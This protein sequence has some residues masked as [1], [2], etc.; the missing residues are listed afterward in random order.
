MAYD[1]SVRSVTMVAGSAVTPYRFLALAATGKVDHVASAGVM[2]D[3][4]A[5]EAAS[6]VDKT[7][8]MGLPD[9]CVVKV[10]CGGTL[11]RGDKVESNAS[12]Q[13]ITF[14]ATVGHVS[15]GVALEAG[16]ASRIISILFKNQ[17]ANVGT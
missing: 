11:A 8:P 15:C 13:A 12:G 3:G 5:L 1:E 16:V 14:P 7:L 9:G 4:V 10:E 2:P 6:G 17:G